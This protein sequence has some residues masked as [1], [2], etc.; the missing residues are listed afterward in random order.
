MSY[1]RLRFT[2]NDVDDTPSSIPFPSMD[3]FRR[4]DDDAP[5]DEDRALK[6][7]REIEDALDDVQRRLDDVKD[8]LDGAFRMPSSSDNWPPAA[9]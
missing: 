5:N 7:A 3:Q 2:E 9:A 8:Q 1:L 4:A 6:L